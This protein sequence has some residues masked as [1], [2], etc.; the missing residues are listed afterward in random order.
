M[1]KSNN[2]LLQTFTKEELIHMLDQGTVA[3]DEARREIALQLEASRTRA[4]E[5]LIANKFL[6][7]EAAEKER[8]NAAFL[9]ARKEL[10]HQDREKGKRADEL[11][12][13]NLERLKR[14]EEFDEVKRDLLFQD[15]E[16]AKLEEHLF[17]AQKV[18]S[19]GL[20]TGGVAHDMNNVLGAILGLA[21]TMLETQ[22]GDTVTARAF[23]TIARAA[24]RGG[25]LVKS[26]L[27]FSHKRLAEEK[28]LDL[29]E[30]VRE[31]LGI[32][33]RTTAAGIRIETDLEADLR[34]TQG[35]GNALLSA[36]LNLCTNAVDAMGETGT[37]TLTTRNVDCAWVELLVADTGG[38]MSRETLDRAMDPFFTTKEVGKGTGLGLAMVCR[39]VKAHHGQVDIQSEPQRGTRVRLRLPACEPEGAGEPAQDEDGPE[40]AAPSGV[41]S[42]LV[43]DDD[44]LVQ[45]SLTIILEQ[46]GHGVTLAASGEEALDRLGQ[47]LRPDVVI[48]DMNMPGLGGAGTLPRLRALWPGLPVLLST[49]RVD[50]AA[51]A[52]AEAHPHVQLLPKPFNVKEFKRTLKAAQG[53]G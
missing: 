48:L 7:S 52:L 20:L 36:I 53:G 3:L 8:R 21:S 29:K 45:G 50:Q 40:P 28:E 26:L 23:H 43:V 34:P 12:A 46:L 51:I 44:E 27:A 13:A 22:P 2:A 14:A 9:L 35:D 31:A 42:V 1:S 10:V 32:L 49:G 15:Q 19:L 17:Q 18:E 11:K 16:N 33:R 47:G 25:L 24:T 30:V 38:G 6:L 41:V 4:G 39:T 5:L 37:L